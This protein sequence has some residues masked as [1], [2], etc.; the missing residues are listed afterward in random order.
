MPDLNRR[1]YLKG[2]AVGAGSFAGIAGV[3]DVSSP[4]QA[5]SEATHS[6][7]APASRQEAQQRGGGRICPSGTEQ[8]ATYEANDQGELELT[9][10]DDVVSFSNVQRND[11]GEVVG[12][13]WESSE[14]V[15]V[16]SVKHG[17]NRTKAEGGFTGSVD[18]SDEQQAIGSVCICGP[19]GGRAVICELDSSVDDETLYDAEMHRTEDPCPSERQGVVHVTSN[20][21]ETT[22]YAHGMVN[23]VER[24]GRLALTELSG[25]TFGYVEGGDIEQPLPDEV[26][27]AFMTADGDETLHLA[28]VHLDDGKAAD[29]EK[30]WREL[31]VH[32]ALQEEMWTVMELGIEDFASSNAAEQAAGQ[33]KE[34]EKHDDLMSAFGDATLVGVGFGAGNTETPTTLHRFYDDLVVEWDGGSESFDFPA[35]VPMDVTFDP[36]TIEADRGGRL[37]ATLTLAEADQAK[38]SLDDVDTETVKLTGLQSVAPPLEEGVAPNNVKVQGDD[39]VAQFQRKRVADL[40]GEGDNRPIVSGDFDDEWGTAFFGVGELTVE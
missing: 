36:E 2:A 8:I 29:H 25:L 27:V 3:T 13:D 20:G 14:P 12:F 33:L 19:R 37:V 6:R 31:D 30:V 17:P 38:L 35:S 9:S 1:T 40:L 16:V 26:F 23:V 28:F 5:A 34:A 7:T 18:L 24:V 32:A 10:G 39:L 4:S 21:E 15:A 22:D 11:E